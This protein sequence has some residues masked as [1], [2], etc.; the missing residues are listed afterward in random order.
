M[1]EEVVVIPV[2]YCPVLEYR[3]SQGQYTESPTPRMVAY[4]PPLYPSAIFS[5]MATTHS[6]GRDG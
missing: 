3:H 1:G 4:P 5:C 6:A 2:L